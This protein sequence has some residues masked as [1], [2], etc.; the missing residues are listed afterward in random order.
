[1]DE[2]RPSPGDGPLGTA[3]EER[4]GAVVVVV[5]GEID[6]A[7]APRLRAAVTDAAERL[8]G[9]RLVVDLAGVRFL[10]SAGMAVLA[11]AADRV[12]PAPLA[13]VVGP[14]GPVGRTLALAGMDLTVRVVA[15]VEDALR[16]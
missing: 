14:D 2:D 13:V 8:A 6:L 10:G 11:A 7:T 12:E 16:G 9:R 5:S 4:D 3:C 1:M 15:R